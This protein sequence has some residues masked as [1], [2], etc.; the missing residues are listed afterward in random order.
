MGR[1]V[2]KKVIRINLVGNLQNFN[3]NHIVRELFMMDDIS[4]INRNNILEFGGNVIDHMSVNS[5]I[6]LCNAIEAF[7]MS[8]ICVVDKTTNEHNA[9]YDKT[10]SINISDINTNSFF[11]EGW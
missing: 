7:N 11:A 9:K 6:S 1:T 8:A 4:F 5:R 10:I 2:Q 3:V